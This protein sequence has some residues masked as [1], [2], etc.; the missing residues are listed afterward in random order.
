MNIASYPP[1]K[2]AGYTFYTS[3]VSQAN[4]NIMQANPTLAAGDVQVATDD[5]APA[6]IATLPVV[7][8]DF[9]KRIKVVLSAAEMNGDNVT[10]IFSDVAGA[11][12]CDMTVNLQTSARQMDDLA[13]PNVSGRGMDVDAGGGVEL[14]AVQT[15]AIGAAA[16]AAGAVDA[17]AIAANAI[18]ASEL[19]QDA[20]QEIA[21]EMLNRNLAGGGSGGTRNVR[22]ALRA[23]RNKT[24]IAAGTLTVTEE[25]DTTSAWTAAVTTAAGNPI[26]SIDPV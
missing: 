24:S 25:D 4:P 5:G 23:L 20:A 7:D 26:S 3:L 9:S 2:N 13:F 6:N 22:N 8:A 19:A 11:E 15:G 1:K 10:I 18:G 17:A 16:F 14:G 12:W 21:D